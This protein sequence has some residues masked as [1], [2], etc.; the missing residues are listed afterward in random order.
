MSKTRNELQ[1]EIDYLKS[2]IV[3]KEAGIKNSNTDI[4][5]LQS[6]LENQEQLVIE[7]DA[8]IEYLEIQYD[9]GIL[10]S[11][12][13]VRQKDK[14]NEILKSESELANNK[15]KHLEKMAKIDFDNYIFRTNELEKDIGFYKEYFYKHSSATFIE[16]LNYLLTGAI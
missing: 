10:A 2:M 16:R 13:I 6:K 14:E 4:D 7:K 12:A 3:E 8:R 1:K 5:I 11:K 9:Q 15:I